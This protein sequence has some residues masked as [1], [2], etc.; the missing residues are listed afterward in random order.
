MENSH[1]RNDSVCLYCWPHLH[2]YHIIIV[3]RRIWVYRRYRHDIIIQLL[4]LLLLMMMM[5]M[6]TKRC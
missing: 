5:M 4:L 2:G 1:S 6:M 3:L